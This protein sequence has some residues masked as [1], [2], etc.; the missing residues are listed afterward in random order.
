MKPIISDSEGSGKF[1]RVE[2]VRRVPFSVIGGTEVGACSVLK[3][4]LNKRCPKID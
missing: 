4:C 3:Q 1:G 2:E